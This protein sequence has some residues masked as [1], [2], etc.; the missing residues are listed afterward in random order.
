MPAEVKVA[1]EVEDTAGVVPAAA[2]EEDPSGAAS[3]RIPAEAASD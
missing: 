1:A 2:T 3:T